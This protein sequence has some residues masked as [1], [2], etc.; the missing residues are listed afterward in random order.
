MLDATGVRVGELEA[1]RVADLD[2]TRKAWLIRAAVAKTRRARWVQLPDDLFEA[3]I[4]RLPAL[5]DRTPETPLFASATAD[6]LRVAIGRACRDAGVPH[7]SPHDLGHRRISLLHRQGCS[8][9]EIGEQVGQ[10]SRIVTADRYTHALL[11]Y[12]EVD[13][14]KMLERVRAVQTP[15]QTS[16]ELNPS[17]AGAF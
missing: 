11:D 9:A 17:F 12:T 7:F 5:E 13:R 14:A 6:R 10:R 8:W 16:E 2:E 4:A 1:A 15:V 3:I